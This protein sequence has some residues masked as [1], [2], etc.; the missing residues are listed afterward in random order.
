[1]ITPR[2]L[3]VLAQ[4]TPRRFGDPLMAD[5]PLDPLDPSAIVRGDIVGIVNSA[6]VGRSALR[7]RWIAKPCRRLFTASPMP[8]LAVPC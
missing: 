2:W 6:R 7:A 3:Y 1:M 5:E 4:A 8:E